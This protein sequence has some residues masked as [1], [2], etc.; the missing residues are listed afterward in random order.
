ME[1]YKSKRTLKN[2]QL[3]SSSIGRLEKKKS[4]QKNKLDSC[5]L[6]NNDNNFKDYKNN[7]YENTYL[8]LDETSCQML[9]P[10][11]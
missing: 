11:K 3:T 5:K 6:N 7:Q 9:N 1:N 4:K 2:K 10:S 8:I